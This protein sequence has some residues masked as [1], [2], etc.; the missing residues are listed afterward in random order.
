MKIIVLGAGVVGV[1]SAYFLREQGH[2]VTV[3]E[4][5]AQVA[6][7]TSY[8]NGG[9]ISVSGAEPW[10]NPGVP[11]QLLAWLGHED[12]PLRLRLRADPRQWAWCLRFLQECLP[13]RTARNMR[14]LV[15][16]GLYS[17]EVLRA[18]RKRRDLHYDKQCR[19]ILHLY[20]DAR[21]L[22]GA[23]HCTRQMR[24]LGCE[25]RVVD[26]AEAVRIEPALASMR[27]R[28]VGAT[29]TA[30]DESGDANAFARQLAASCERDGVRFR[31][32]H[33]ITA[34]R[35]SADSVDHVELT[36]PDGGFERMTADAYVLTS[37]C[38]SAPL[39]K[40]LGIHLPLY[41]VKGYSVTLPVA[42]AG[43]A[44][45]VSLTDEQ[46]KLVFS[47][48]GDRL[49][50]AGTAEVGGW[51]RELDSQRCAAIVAQVNTMFPGAADVSRARYWA[52]L[53]PMT[54]GNVPIVGRS[55]L[56]NLY[57][58]TGHGSLGWTLACGSA[59]GLASIVG[60]RRPDV[61]FA[62]SGT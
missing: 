30:D 51:T 1:A 52:G 23:A 22:D 62:F 17:R 24:E 45:Q 12:A 3:I 26:V 16:L 34:L 8:A 11:R 6:A 58:N 46:H 42:D 19:G 21:A 36:N 35:R 28:L 27:A 57:L 50:V 7:R 32:G 5:Q 15:Q 39:A 48:L 60:G 13:W 10:A 44:W 40:T 38:W 54:P 2:D 47:R 20:T 29:Y 37:G 14:E 53:R 31:F 18:L 49:R 4:R 33:T 56:R 59:A 41:P 61:A 9:Q 43:A 55:R 25:R